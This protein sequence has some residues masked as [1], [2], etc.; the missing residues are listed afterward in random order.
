[1]RSGL[2]MRSLL[3]AAVVLVGLAQGL[4]AQTAPDTY[5]DPQPAKPAAN[6]I[7][8][9]GE[10]TESFG[11]N[12]PEFRGLQPDLR[13][14]YN[15]A[16]TSR[17]GVDNFVAFG[18]RLAGLSVIERKSVGGGVP[19]FDDGQDVYILD[20]Q[21]L[22]ACEDGAAT[23]KWSATGAQYPIRYK[24]TVASAS[25]SSGGNY[26]TR[27]ESYRKIVFAGNQF[28]VTDPDGTRYVYKSPG[29]IAG[30]TSPWPGDNWKM[31]NRLY[32]YLTEITDSQKDAAGNYTNKVTISYNIGPAGFG[33]PAVPIN[34]S[35]GGYQA[36]LHY[37][38]VGAGIADFGTGTPAI[39]RQFLRL[40]AV[41]VYD[42]GAKIRAYNLITTQSALTQTTLL[43]RVESYGSD[44][45]IPSGI[46][47]A[48]TKLPD[49]SYE[50]AADTYS[51]AAQTYSGK[52]FH[53]SNIIADA[54]YN[55]TDDL[56]LVGGQVYSQRQCGGKNNE[57]TCYT[58]VHT[59]S[60]AR[61]DFDS[62]K[63][64]I[65]KTPVVNSCVP[66]LPDPASGPTALI[67]PN[68]IDVLT[69]DR[70]T[71]PLACALSSVSAI[72]S[73]QNGNNTTYSV[74]L[75]AYQLGM[76]VN[77]ATS[78]ANIYGPTINQAPPSPHYRSG[79][80]DL[81][82]EAE[83]LTRT[84]IRDVNDA[85]I[86]AAGGLT[87]T[88]DG[89]ETIGDFDGDGVQDLVRNPTTGLPNEF[90]TILKE[91]GYLGGVWRARGYVRSWPLPALTTGAAGA[92]INGDG[93]LDL[94]TYKTNG[95][96]ADTLEVRLSSGGQF[97]SPQAIP[98]AANLSTASAYFQDIN[99]DGL[100]DLILHTGFAGFPNSPTNFYTSQH[101]YIFLNRGLSNGFWLLPVNGQGSFPGYVGHGDF[102]GN[103]LTDFVIEGANGQIYWG[104]GPVPNRLVAVNRSSGGRTEVSYVSSAQFGANQMPAVQQVV[105]SIT[106]KDGRGTSRTTSYGYIGGKYD[107]INRKA[108]GYNTVVAY[109]P[110]IAGETAAP[111]VTTIYMNDNFANAGLVKSQIV[112]VGGTTTLSRLINDWAVT[113]GMANANTTLEGGGPFTIQKVKERTAIGSGSV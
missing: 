1:M 40:Q 13:L 55:G 35:Y 53:R 99:T 86:G 5:L 12:L 16:N 4:S 47:T 75:S 108:L 6:L 83:I 63:N 8:A 79:N 84:V 15:S 7:G 80:F 82:A 73:G 72:P 90:R 44:F 100:T 48:G 66:A 85:V 52:E 45:Q 30:D 54:D 26:T 22:M 9:G 110:P 97:Q 96:S 34:I 57:H 49:V 77:G 21:E 71:S 78:S 91:D 107:F 103:G 27:V 113:P 69:N 81:D 65:A 28:T 58:L 39:G 11:F 18:W 93:V 102:D 29:A 36:H 56:L 106:E 51:L 98:L 38:Y 94:A 46:V 62:G 61:S 25:C 19:T 20:G 3:G 64:L 70:G 87:S 2:F 59:Y 109:L 95:T 76:T 17:G 37:S 42:N 104:N 67:N 33:F 60:T 68:S 41:A 23:N 111:V 112:S 101:A 105:G 32:W 24:T 89:T 31:A 43:Q 14:V 10:Y 92:D 74:A 88:L 50:Y